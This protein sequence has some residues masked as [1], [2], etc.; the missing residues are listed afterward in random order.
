MSRSRQT[1]RSVPSAAVLKGYYRALTDLVNVHDR[2]PAQWRYFQT[3]WLWLYVRGLNE[4]V[5][6]EEVRRR[7]IEELEE[8][9]AVKSKRDR[10]EAEEEQAALRRSALR[11][12]RSP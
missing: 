8:A 7:R 12:V 9:R 11:V 1:S 10:V 2:T 3:Q 4:G 6:A 5:P